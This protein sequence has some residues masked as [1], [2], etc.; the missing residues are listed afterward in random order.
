VVLCSRLVD[1]VVSRRAARW[2]IAVPP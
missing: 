2:I 1:A